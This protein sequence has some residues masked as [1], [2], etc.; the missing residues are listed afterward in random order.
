MH[1]CTSAHLYNCT[2]S[3][4]YICTPVQLYTCTPVQLHTCTSAHLH[5]CTIAHMYICTPVQL[6]TWTPVRSVSIVSVSNTTNNTNALQSWSN[7]TR[8]SAPAWDIQS[9]A[10]TQASPSHR[11]DFPHVTFN[12]CKCTTSNPSPSKKKHEVILSFLRPFM[13]QSGKGNQKGWIKRAE[14]CGWKLH[15]REAFWWGWQP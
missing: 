15:V 11:Q 8:R 10:T 9:C 3:H 13:C 6:Y 12:F 7:G 5:T 14:Y 1:N 4:V 2:L